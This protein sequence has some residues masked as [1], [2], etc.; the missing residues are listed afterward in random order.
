MPS[1]S[2]AARI[3]VILQVQRD[4]PDCYAVDRTLVAPLIHFDA[5]ILVA[6][7]GERER[8]AQRTGGTARTLADYLAALDVAFEVA[9]RWGAAGAK[10]M[11]AYHRPRQHRQ[12]VRAEIPPL[13]DRPDLAEADA[14]I[15]QDLMAHAVAEPA[16][17]WAR[18][19]QVHVGYGPWQRN[20]TQHANPLLLDPLIDAHPPT[21]SVLVHGGYPFIRGPEDPGEDPCQ[22]VHRV[23]LA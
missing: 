21:Q 2:V 5:W 8:V 23:R 22:R 16:G 15:F 19:Y 10:S 9:C 14:G 7:P 18:P 11:L 1:A 20:I 3:P 12:P 4:A 13:F 17:Q 6:E